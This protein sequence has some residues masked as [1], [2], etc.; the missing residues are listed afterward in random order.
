MLSI[1]HRLIEA[2]N[3]SVIFLD[4]PEWLMTGEDYDA[5]D[6]LAWC[7]ENGITTYDYRQAPVTLPLD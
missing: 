5:K 6:L 4:G 1:A 7:A 2:L 3:P